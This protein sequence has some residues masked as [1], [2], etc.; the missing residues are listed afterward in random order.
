MR[1]HRA[2]RATALAVALGAALLP[3][4][5]AAA[6]PIPNVSTRLSVFH[7][8]E[9]DGEYFQTWNASNSAPITAVAAPGGERITFSG[10]G[11]TLQLDQAAGTPW[12]AGQFQ[13]TGSTAADA[14]RASVSRTG[15]SCPSAVGAADADA[16]D[17][18]VYQLDESAPDVISHLS[19]D[20]IVFCGGRPLYF[21]LRFD[22]DPR[23]DP[24]DPAGLRIAGDTRLETA[25][26]AALEQFPKQG[27]V[28]DEFPPADTVVLARSD[29]YADALAGTPLAVKLGGPLLLT[30]RD[31][32]D[33]GVGTTIGLVL[34]PGKTI[35]ILGG[36]TAVGP[37]VEQSLE[38]AGYHVVRHAGV[39]RFET[40][41]KIADAMGNPAQALL[42]TGRN[43]P[44]GLSAGA[45]A[46]VT[47][48]AILLTDGPTMPA[49]TTAYLQVHP[50]ALLAVGGPASLAAGPSVPRIAGADRYETSAMLA[51]QYFPGV[52]ATAGIASG[53]NFQDAL[54][55][56][57]HVARTG[58]P[59]LLV[60]RTSIPES[61]VGVLDRVHDVLYVYGGEQA[62]SIEA[63][64]SITPTLQSVH[65]S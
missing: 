2:R 52:L 11:W 50:T 4:L 24:I 15:E 33:P 22:A 29:D 58:G 3:V 42:V 14:V 8:P 25:E 18:F 44:D 21:E 13:L 20:L 7:D 47:R 57:T 30:P 46:A 6:Q 12:D 38:D 54:S 56:G 64:E 40:A 28:T 37:A 59:L 39:D 53:E 36:T 19:A 35:H 23:F 34:P 48:T 16:P 61:A 17:L 43:F 65:P 41:A 1:T 5:P 10:G 62:I 63:P 45:V 32:L 27:A 49:A 51:D 26:L 9:A 31:A 55:G 60:H